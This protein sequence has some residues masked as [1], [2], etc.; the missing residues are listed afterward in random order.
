[1]NEPRYQGMTCP[2]TGP[3]RSNWPPNSSCKRCT[4]AV[5]CC[6]GKPVTVSIGVAEQQVNIPKYRCAWSMSRCSFLESGWYS[7]QSYWLSSNWLL[8]P[9]CW[10]PDYCSRSPFWVDQLIVLCNNWGIVSWSDKHT[11]TMWTASRLY[12]IAYL[13]KH[14]GSASMSHRNDDMNFKCPSWAE[15]MEAFRCS[16]PSPSL[17]EFLQPWSLGPA[18]G[19]ENPSFDVPKGSKRGTCLVHWVSMTLKQLDVAVVRTGI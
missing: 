16:W 19:Y 8:W 11:D 18:V 13:F 12:S 4:V 9:C 17:A 10:W 1:M 6:K 5:V 7:D 14:M 2:L 3:S 15:D